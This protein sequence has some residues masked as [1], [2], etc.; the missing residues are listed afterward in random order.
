ME[1]DLSGGEVVNDA[2]DNK[3]KNASLGLMAEKLLGDEF[4]EGGR[5]ARANSF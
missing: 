1:D 2:T 5:S 3:S 4:V